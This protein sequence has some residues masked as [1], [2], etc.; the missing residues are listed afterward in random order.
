[1]E[2]LLAIDPG[3]LEATSSNGDTALHCA[4]SNCHDEIVE[5]LLARSPTLVDASSCFGA[6]CNSNTGRGEKVVLLLLDYRPELIASVSKNGNTL[7]HH[8]V[9]SQFSND[10]L[11]QVW[12]RSHDA[13]FVVNNRKCTPFRVALLFARGPFAR[14]GELAKSSFDEAVRGM[15]VF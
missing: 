11:L 5:L 10:F 9:G 8:A 12:Q 4:A 13:F 7:L 1:M 2:Q 3:L 6:L 15:Q 14:G